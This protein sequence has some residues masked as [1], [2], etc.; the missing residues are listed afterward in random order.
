LTLTG[1]QFSLNVPVV[2]SLGGTGLTS[3][4]TGDMVYYATGS[5]LSKLAIGASSYI[6]TSTGSAPQWSDPNGVTVGTATNAVNV[7]TTATST[8]ANFFIPFVP[9]S[10]TGNQALGVDAGLSYNP[11]TNAITAGISGGIF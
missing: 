10:T 3:Y 4:A 11:S 1:T 5:A 9:A 8:N 2:T 6:M 7:G